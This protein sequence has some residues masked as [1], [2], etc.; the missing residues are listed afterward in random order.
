MDNRIQKLVDLTKNKLQLNNYYLKR[1]SLDRR[2]NIYKET[3]YHLNMEW[4]PNDQDV[5]KDEDSNPQ[6]AAVISI[7]IES[8]KFTQIIFVKGESLVNDYLFGQ[9]SKG[10]I[11]SWIE[12]ETGY[13]YESDFILKKESTGKY[14]FSACV[15][16]VKS[17]PEG[18]IQLEHDYLGRLTLFSVEGEF[19]RKDFVVKSED[20][21]PLEEVE[22][23]VKDQLK[24]IN[25]PSDLTKMQI[26]VYIIDEVF[27]KKSGLLTTPFKVFDS[28]KKHYVINQLIYWETPLKTKFKR[29]DLELSE[30][31]S[32]EQVFAKEKSPDT[33]PISSLQR[34]ECI[35]AVKDF[36]RQV[37]PSDSGKWILDTLNRDH[38]YIHA[39]LKEK[40]AT[41]SLLERKIT[42]MID[43]EKLQ[44]INYIDNEPLLKLINEYKENHVIMV[45]KKLAFEV[46]HEY[47]TFEPYYVFDFEKD[48]YIFAK[49]LSCDYALNA[50]NGKVTLLNEIE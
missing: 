20:K 38:G 13:A 2:V 22:H 48:K 6:G 21:L 28:V 14:V 11:I 37:Y 34:T 29:E 8:E 27:I 41:Q 23:L 26:P 39:V 42:V 7:D 1:Y 25:I 4:F 50:N 10:E 24:L 49:K 43:R 44:V 16:G 17:F 31:I 3:N 33:R 46:I 36:L 45:S 47:I 19:P 15:D 9:S 18:S 40:E 12:S 35:N 5:S 30:E 32:I